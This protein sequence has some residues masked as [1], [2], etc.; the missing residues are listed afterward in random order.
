[1][2]TFI[3]ILYWNNDKHETTYYLTFVY[4]LSRGRKTIDV[5]FN[6]DGYYLKEADDN[7]VTTKEYN[8]KLKKDVCAVVESDRLVEIILY[9]PEG[10]EEQEI[11]VYRNDGIPYIPA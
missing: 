2:D 1:M 10:P 9:G 7:W 8:F 3:D 6:K 5:R 4:N 11:I